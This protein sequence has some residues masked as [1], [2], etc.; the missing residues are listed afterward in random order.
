[1]DWTFAQ[2]LKHILNRPQQRGRSSVIEG[3]YN[4]VHFMHA[5]ATQIGNIVT[6]LTKSG[7]T[8]EGIF[9]TVSP[10]LE[11]VLQIAHQ[12]KGKYAASFLCAQKCSHRIEKLKVRIY[13]K[14]NI[15]W[16]HL[17]G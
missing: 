10:Q 15:A 4:N 3:V 5:I 13:L 14:R 9:Y 11:I 1:M 6:V 17:H 12:Q 8:F 16:L 2:W 7:A